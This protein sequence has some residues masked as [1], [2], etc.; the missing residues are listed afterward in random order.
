MFD[1]TVYHLT[2]ISGHIDKLIEKLDT[3]NQL[4]MILYLLTS[5]T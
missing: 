1:E 3:Q 4:D 2:T 5:F